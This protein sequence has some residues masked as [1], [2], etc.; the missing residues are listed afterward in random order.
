MPFYPKYSVPKRQVGLAAA[1]AFMLALSSVS[2]IDRR[3]PAY[4][5]DQV[6]QS[7]RGGGAGCPQQVHQGILCTSCTYGTYYL[8]MECVDTML[9]LTL[10]AKLV[11]VRVHA[12]GS[13][14]EGRA[15]R[16]M[17]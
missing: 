14:Y 8:P 10:V 17:R 7:S 5:T 12:F 9:L 13:V 3:A 4:T 11:V 6:L 1:T 16:N 2:L 15:S